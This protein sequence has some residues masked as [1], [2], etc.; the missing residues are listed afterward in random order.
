MSMQRPSA[1]VL[2]T[3]AVMLWANAAPCQHR[4][5]PDNLAPF[6]PTPEAVVDKM[7]TAA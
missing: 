6:V 2:A 1:S 7:L 5:S 4:M 3:V